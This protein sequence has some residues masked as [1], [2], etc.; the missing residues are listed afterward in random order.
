MQ[1]FSY[2]II[3]LDF[4][5]LAIWRINNMNMNLILIKIFQKSLSYIEIVSHLIDIINIY[6][7]NKE[8]FIHHKLI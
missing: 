8:N 7:E 1:V 4:I 3:F 6:F 5:D 2:D